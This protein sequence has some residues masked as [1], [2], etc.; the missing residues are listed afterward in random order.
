M[1][2]YKPGENLK[3]DVWTIFRI[4]LRGNFDSFLRCH[5][6]ARIFCNILERFGYD[7]EV[8]D[9]FYVYDEKKLW[10]SWVEFV[11]LYET[12]IIE[13]N[14]QQVFPNLSGT[15]LLKSLLI[16]QDDERFTRYCPIS[17]KEFLEFCKNNNIQIDENQVKLLSEVIFQSMKK[18]IVRK[19]RQSTY[20]ET[21]GNREVK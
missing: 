9:G 12:I 13:T 1:V 8:V 21:E 20:E 5:E 3:Q 6:S 17:K 4:I 2:R 18:V 7:V 10:H 15:E 14:P 11:D 16:S 19:N